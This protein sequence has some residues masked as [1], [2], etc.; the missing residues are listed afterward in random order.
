M[1]THSSTLAR[2]SQGQRRREVYS[3]YGRRVG[4][5]RSDLAHMLSIQPHHF[6]DKGIEAQRAVMT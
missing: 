6:T 3:P 2:E 5:D 4:H 1:T